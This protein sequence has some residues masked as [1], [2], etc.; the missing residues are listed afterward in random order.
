MLTGGKKYGG[1]GLETPTI[2]PHKRKLRI[3]LVGLAKGG[4]TAVHLENLLRIELEKSGRGGLPSEA[5][6]IKVMAGLT[7]YITSLVE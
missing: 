2:Q 7:G 1:L 5:L 4:L 3:V 6:T